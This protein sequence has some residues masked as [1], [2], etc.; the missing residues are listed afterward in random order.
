MQIT[1]YKLVKVVDDPL[2]YLMEGDIDI[3]LPTP[4]LSDSENLY[5]CQT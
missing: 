3:S 5:F 1:F 2:T 4:A